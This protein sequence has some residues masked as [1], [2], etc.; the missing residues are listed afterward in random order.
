[1]SAWLTDATNCPGTNPTTLTCVIPMLNL[2]SGSYSYVLDDL[3]KV[4]VSAYN[5]IGYGPTST[6]NTSGA[7]VR[8][9]PIAMTTPSKGSLTTDT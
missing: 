7:L 6:I 3:V 9:L 4:R 1:M 2:L 8:T 5:V